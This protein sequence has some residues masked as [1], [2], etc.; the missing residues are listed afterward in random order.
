M[1]CSK[2]HKSKSNF[3]GYFKNDTWHGMQYRNILGSLKSITIIY[4]Y[5]SITC[6]I[7]NSAMHIHDSQLAIYTKEPCMLFLLQCTLFQAINNHM[8]K[9]KGTW[10]R[11]LNW[12]EIKN[13]N[14]KSENNMG[15]AYPS[16]V[17]T[18]ERPNHIDGRLISFS[19]FQF[20]VSRA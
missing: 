9:N 7:D 20:I 1:L 11:K 2:L 16:H 13:I 17:R 15:P 18:N 6:Y 10:V 3:V 14:N 5:V 4:I 8:N 19:N 12:L